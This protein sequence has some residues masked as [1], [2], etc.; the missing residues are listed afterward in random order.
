MKGNNRLKFPYHGTIKAI[1][2]EFH[3][4]PRT[5]SR[6]V[7]VRAQSKYNNTM[8]VS[9]KCGVPE[10]WTIEFGQIS[11]SLQADTLIRQSILSTASAKIVPI[12][13]QFG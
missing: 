9:Q 8:I 7:W 13:R 6:R 2:A 11:A 4:H 12:H 5:L 10:K 3:V 1:A